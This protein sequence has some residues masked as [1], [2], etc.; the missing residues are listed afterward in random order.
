MPAAACVFAAKGDLDRAIADLARRSASIRSTRWR[1]TGAALPGTPKA[2]LA[3]AIADYD[4][5]IRLDPGFGDAYATRGM[6]WHAEGDL[7]RAAADLT[8]AIRVR[9]DQ[10]RAV[11]RPRRRAPPA[12]RPRPRHRGLQRGRDARA[13]HGARLHQPRRGVARQG[14]ARPRH[15]RPRRG[16]RLAPASAVDYHNRGS[17]LAGQG[18]PRPRPHRS[19]RGASARSAECRC[20][21]GSRPC[22]VRDGRSRGRPPRLP[23]GAPAQAEPYGGGAGRRPRLV[24]ARRICPGGRPAA[25]HRRRSVRDA[26]PLPGA[27]ARRSKGRRRA[28]RQCGAACRARRGPI[29]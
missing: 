11:P 22:P 20:L 16:D 29:R 17:E 10:R 13:G 23:C 14:P 18:R 5:A 27:R 1:S 12:G 24:R 25:L 26:V 7:A 19:R 21:C 8:E 9:S 15:R 3:C 4:E 28:C 2:E 6:A